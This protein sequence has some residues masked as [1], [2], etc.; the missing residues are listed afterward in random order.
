MTVFFVAAEHDVTNF[1]AGKTVGFFRLI[2]CWLLEAVRWRGFI[3]RP[4]GSGAGYC[5]YVSAIFK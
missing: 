2:P 5:T 3:A 4:F 1:Q